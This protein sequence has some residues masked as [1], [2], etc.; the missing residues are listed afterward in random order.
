MTGNRHN[1]SELIVLRPVIIRLDEIRALS[2]FHPYSLPP[3][4][5]N[6]PIQ[7]LMNKYANSPFNELAPKKAD[8]AAKEDAAI[9]NNASRL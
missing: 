5:P 3:T 8:F 4:F 7:H 9:S 1:Q 6:T 2:L